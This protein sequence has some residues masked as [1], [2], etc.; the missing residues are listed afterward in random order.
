MTPV[1]SSS[2]EMMKPRPAEDAKYMKLF[3]PGFPS[4]NTIRTSLP[5]FGVKLSC[6]CLMFADK[7]QGRK[8]YIDAG[9]DL[10][11]HKISKRVTTYLHYIT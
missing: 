6:V 2:S 8:L 7:K 1:T 10:K 5:Y 11:I 9:K 3:F 4:V